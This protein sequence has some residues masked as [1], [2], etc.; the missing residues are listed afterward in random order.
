[1]FSHTHVQL[2]IY[3]P[4]CHKESWFTEV[5]GRVSEIC[6]R[7]NDTDDEYQNIFSGEPIEEMIGNK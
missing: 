3:C 2:I 7:C 4:V 6:D 5:Y 1:M